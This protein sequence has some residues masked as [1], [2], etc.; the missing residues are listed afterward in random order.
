M[1]DPPS[2]TIDTAVH[3]TRLARRAVDEDEAAAYRRERDETLA[4]FGYET[5]VREEGDRAV[6]V[7]Y[8]A[9]WMTDGTVQTRRI[10]DLDR[11]V[12]R[13][14]EGTGEAGEFDRVER[15]NRA[16]ADAVEAAA[17]PV[18]GANAHAFADFMGNHHVRR[19]E[20]ATRAELE[21]FLMEYFPRNAWPTA[22][23]RERVRESL[24]LVFEATDTPVPPGIDG[25]KTDGHP[26]ASSRNHNRQG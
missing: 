23:Q 19:V 13:P 24:R 25:D 26:G 17:G 22:A 10:D 9:E 3:L 16:V 11:A 18:H 6:L 21:A 15:H 20:S 8:P 14:L 12:E 1:A 4:E 2:E 7:C 5:R